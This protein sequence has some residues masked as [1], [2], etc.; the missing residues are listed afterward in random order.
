[1][2][3]K[4]FSVIFKHRVNDKRSLLLGYLLIKEAI[5]ISSCMLQA[6]LLISDWN[7]HLKKSQQH[8]LRQRNCERTHLFLAYRSNISFTTF[9]PWRIF[10]HLY[11]RVAWNSGSWGIKKNSFTCDNIILCSDMT[12]PSILTDFHNLQFFINFHKEQGVIFKGL[13]FDWK[14]FILTNALMTKCLGNETK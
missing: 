1:M 7:Y 8:V 10:L 14:I 2:L 13:M 11:A 12:R 4:T 5:C 6:L 3:N 9:D